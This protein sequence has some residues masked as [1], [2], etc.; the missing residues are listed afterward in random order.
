MV[1]PTE[2]RQSGTLAHPRLAESSGAAV[3]SGSPGVLWTMSDRRQS[4]PTSPDRHHR[5]P[6]HH[7]A[8]DRRHQHRLGGGGARALPGRPLPL[9][10]R[11]RRQRRTPRRSEPLIRLIEPRLTATLHGDLPPRSAETLSLPLPGR[12][13]RCRGDGSE[14][15]RRRPP[16]HQGAQRRRP[17]LPSSRG[18]LGQGRRSIAERRRFAADHRRTAALGRSG[19]WCRPLRPMAAELM[20]RTYRDLYPFRR[21]PDRYGDPHGQADRLRHPRPRAAGRRVRL[22]R[23]TSAGADE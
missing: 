3:T 9:H 1:P 17:P 21:P 23:P 7:P 13:P 10:R 4:A 6:A 16:G 20:V 12:R 14:R 18:E 2:L 22:A 15:R 19:D 11:H 5:R 8:A